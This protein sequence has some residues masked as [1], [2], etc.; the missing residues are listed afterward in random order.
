MCGTIKGILTLSQEICI[1]DRDEHRCERMKE[2]EKPE[3]NF[4]HMLVK[5]KSRLHDNQRLE[6]SSAQKL[7][8]QPLALIPAAPAKHFLAQTLDFHLPSSTLQ[9]LD[10]ICFTAAIKWQYTGCTSLLWKMAFG[11]KE[12]KALQ[13]MG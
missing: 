13:L 1:R 2:K 3:L 8:I 6:N 12:Q 10:A 7:I 9:K 11:N 5:T 4:P